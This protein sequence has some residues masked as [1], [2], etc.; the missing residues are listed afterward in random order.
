MKKPVSRGIV[1]DNIHGFH[2]L[3]WEDQESLREKVSGGGAGGG[4]GSSKAKP[5]KANPDGLQCDYAKSSRSSCR[6]CDE[7]IQT[8]ELRVAFMMENDRPFPPKIPAWHHPKCFFENFADKVTAL[9]DLDGHEDLKPYDVKLLNAFINNEPIPE[10]PEEEDDEEATSKPAKGKGKRKSSTQKRKRGAKAEE[11]EEEDEAEDEPEEDEKPKKRAARGRN[12]KAEKVKKE[13]DKAADEPVTGSKNSKGKAAVK[14]EK[15][16]DA[17]PATVDPNVVKLRDQSKAIWEMRDKIKADAGRGLKKWCIEMLEANGYAVHPR[18]TEADL[19]IY[20]ADAM[21]FGRTQKCPEC[22][23]SRLVAKEYDYRCPAQ[24]EWTNC[25]Y[26]T[27]EPKFEAFEIPEDKMDEDWLAEY[28]WQPR[29]RIL[30]QKREAAPTTTTNM[31]EELIKK[32]AEAA[33]RV[34]DTDQPFKGRA[35]SFAGKL[36]KTQAQYKALVEE[37]GGEVVSKIGQDVKFVISNKAEVDKKSTK[38]Q[39]AE[40]WKIDV[41]DES[42]ITDC[43][44]Q[45]K[46]LYHGDPKYILVTNSQEATSVSA[47]EKKRKAEGLEEERSSKVTKL[48]VK[49]GAAV[50]PESGLETSHHVLKEK[51][52]LYSIVLAKADVQTA[53]NSY[54]KLQVLEPDRSGSCHLFRSWGRVGTTVGG[55]KC[56]PVSKQEARETFRVLYLEKCGN[57]FGAPNQTK[58]PGLMFPLE[59]DFGDED[60]KLG[61]SSNV[62]AGSKTKLAKPIQN[63]MQLIFDVK[64]MRET[65]KEMEIDLAKMPLGKISKNMITSA[66][67]CLSKAMKLVTSEETPSHGQI[68]ALSNQFFTLV[69]HD[70]GHENAPLLNNKDIIQSKVEMLDTLRDMEIATTLLKSGDEQKED[71]PIDVHYKSL[72]TRMDVVERGS[73]EYKL[74]EECLRTTH[75]PTHTSY[76]LEIEDVLKVEREGERERFE[77]GGYDKLDNRKVLWHGSRVTNFAGILSQGLRIAPPEAPVTGYMFGKGIYFADM[78]SKSANYC[79]ANPS[80]PTGLLILSEVALGDM[81]ERVDAEYVEKLPKGKS[82]TKGCG[83]TGPTKFVPFP[84]RSFDDSDANINTQGG[85]SKMDVD[86]EASLAMPVGPPTDQ[87]LPSKT[88][89]SSLLYNEYIVYDVSQVVVRY[90]IRVKFNYGRR[91]Y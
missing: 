76:T 33:T 58:R 18:W 24:L 26:A 14:S 22:K 74:V 71:D 83:K 34:I 65:L 5:K 39:Q 19:S 43:L 16:G 45:K 50:D 67:E 36:S 85:S 32:R 41:V 88:K 51:D 54:Y 9:E 73:N 12:A 23:Q 81:Y 91:H 72:K 77:K 38:T 86:G 8:G 64:A 37:G 21:V 42:Y 53:K 4:G 78:V 49:G 27:V 29:E 57:E 28:K 17:A 63:L 68:I 10:K 15:P 62:E 47:G 56:D 82:S 89:W 61:Q 35:F 59:V 52:L 80:N 7:K 13:E 20:L 40:E 87:G 25:T 44:E 46:R 6:G 31:R 69:P 79:F 3:R 30:N 84:Y 11:D 75:A 1:A 2:D 70:F 90:L 66:Y 60:D 48:T 55:V